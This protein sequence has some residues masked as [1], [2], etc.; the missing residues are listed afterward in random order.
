[1]SNST[2]GKGTSHLLLGAVFNR[3]IEWSP[4]S[5]MARAAMENALSPKALDRLFGATAVRQYTRELLFPALVNLMSL[6]VFRIRPSVHAAYQAMKAEVAVSVAAVY[7]KLGRVEPEVAAALV[8][9]SGEKLGTAVEAM[10]GQMEPWLPGYRVRILDG[11]HLA[12]RG[13]PDWTETP[14]A[15]TS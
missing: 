8:Q 6:V 7:E 9:H 1:M 3:F 14:L 10:G 11:N 5:V 15:W 12:A 2:V 13:R 4:I